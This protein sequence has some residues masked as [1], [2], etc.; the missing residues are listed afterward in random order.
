[1]YEFM[2]H[3]CMSVCMWPEMH[4]YMHV[5]VY[6]YICMYTCIAES[7]PLSLIFTGGSYSVSILVQV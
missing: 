2:M 1:M 4:E 7:S 3:Q 5:F 6:I